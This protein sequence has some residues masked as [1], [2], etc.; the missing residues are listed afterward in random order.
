M[1]LS[2]LFMIMASILS[3]LL[4]IMIDII[5]LPS[6]FEKFYLFFIMRESDKWVYVGLGGIYIILHLLVCGLILEAMNL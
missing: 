5:T 6:I 3:I 1:K 4:W 2:V